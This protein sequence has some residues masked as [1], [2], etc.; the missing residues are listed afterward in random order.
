MN[1]AG[2]GVGGGVGCVDGQHVRERERRRE[3]FQDQERMERRREGN[4]LVFTHQLGHRGDMK[5]WRVMRHEGL[6]GKRVCLQRRERLG[7]RD[8]AA[9]SEMRVGRKWTW[10]SR[11]L[12]DVRDSCLQLHLSSSPC[13]PCQHN[14]VYRHVQSCIQLQK[15]CKM[16][17]LTIL[18]KKNT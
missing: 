5:T 7:F 14:C 3:A 17:M 8:K 12:E 1:S 4:L 11:G 2:K 18:E 15:H 6:G 13:S 9:R 10:R 16:D